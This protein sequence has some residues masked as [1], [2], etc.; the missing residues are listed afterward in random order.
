[1][2]PK[3]YHPLI[4]V[5]ELFGLVKSFG[6]IAIYLFVIR[7]GS[8]SGFTYYARIGFV[9][10]L[11]LSMVSIFLKWRTNK[12]EIEDE[13]FHLYS[14]I[15][16][17][18]KQTIPFSRIQNVNRRTSFIHK[19]LSMTSLQFE[20]SMSGN[21]ASIE[22]KMVTKEEAEMLEEMVK[23]QPLNS[24]ELSLAKDN[25][26]LPETKAEDN[27]IVHFTPTRKDLIRASF[28]SLSFLLLIPVVG[29]LFSNFNDVFSIEEE[30]QGLLSALPQTWW[31]YA[32]AAAIIIIASVLFGVVRTFLKYG[33]YVIASDDNR[34][35][36]SKGVLDE[37]AFSI[38]KN[39][40]QAIEIIQT[41]LKRILGLAEVKLTSAGGVGIGEENLEINSLYPFLPV[42]RAYEIIEELLPAYSV[43]NDMKKLP[44]RS[45]WIRLLR[46]SWIWII[47]TITLFIFKP[48]PFDIE[49]A[50][51][52]ISILLLLIT[53]I[54]RVLDYIN[55]QY[56][57]N[58]HFIQMKSGSLS[59]TLFVTKRDKIIEVNV[60]RG[61]LQRQFGL[62]TI[63]TVNRSKPVHH[64]GID[65]IPD[66]LAALFVSWYRERKQEITIK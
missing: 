50:W 37:T 9:L 24:D 39:R 17:K 4:M 11:A 47:A 13:S 5:L 52:L 58:E 18:S 28:T 43:T 41:P 57:I 3:R 12:Y 20:T 36:I 59:T 1:M 35:Y 48:E 40:V 46:P 42:Q 10:V 2:S 19:L 14:G 53:V 49:I 65:D 33:N 23:K 51:W 27:R 29:S 22:F 34:I 21:D 62:A 38:S 45:F 7:F 6:F 31:F 63:G 26:E 54:F 25:E 16:T 32:L 8:D 64:S 61:I 55:S 56:V 60:T 15:F 66:E 30:A 44:R